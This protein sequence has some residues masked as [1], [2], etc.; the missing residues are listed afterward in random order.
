MNI[1][2]IAT[3]F[4]KIDKGSTI[5]TDLAEELANRGNNLTVV[6]AEERRNSKKICFYKERG[7]QVLR[8]PI[9]NIY[10]V[11]FIEKGISL[12]TME[13]FIKFAI[14]KY[15]KNS[16]FDLILYESPPVT[17]CG[18]VKYAKRKFS[19]VTYLMLK[20]I[21]PQNAVD[22]GIM[23]KE[24][25]MFRL[26]KNKEKALY[27]ISDYIGCMSEGNK[28]YILK[29]NKYIDERK[30]QIFR[31]T[32]KIKKEINNNH[33]YEI[34]QKYNIPKES[35]LFIFGG[36][37]G[38]P[39]ATEF[40]CRA[41][42]NL[43]EDKNIFF[44]LVGR[45]TETVKV[46]N[47][48]NENNCI[49]SIYIENLPRE[50]YEKI[51]LESDVGIVLLDHRFTIPNYPSRILSYMEYALPVVVATDI[52]TDFK[53]LIINSNCGLWCESDNLGALCE[54]IRT[55]ANDKE[56]RLKMG[57]SGRRYLE[58]NL[59]VCKSVEQLEL[60]LNKGGKYNV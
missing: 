9:G 17:N 38:R 8:V 20:D 7:C 10:N 16:K 47:F 50:D 6:V 56:L 3:S 5:Y 23:K 37:M 41:I 19:A 33:N 39:Q 45:G 46:K 27:L 18:I 43:K 49:N 12:L 13:Y 55:L 21:F 59:D 57:L 48:I 11:G 58:L 2:Y 1:L 4:P 15:L 40:L 30:V 60:I 51:V 28:Q 53:D 34:R 35:I 26:F 22:I 42:N 29:N 24:S 25:I 44:L 14:K 52:N 31:N 36:N 54:N 32:K